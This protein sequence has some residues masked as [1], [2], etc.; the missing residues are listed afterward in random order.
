MTE[1]LQNVLPL[2]FYSAIEKCSGFPTVQRVSLITEA[3]LQFYRNQLI[4]PLNLKE[5][6][7]TNTWQPTMNIILFTISPVKM[8]LSSR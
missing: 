5:N 1:G 3:P 8:L 7:K 2:G 6:P 4:I